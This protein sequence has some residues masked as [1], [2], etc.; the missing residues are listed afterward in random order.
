MQR[1]LLLL[2]AALIAIGCAVLFLDDT[3]R[4]T[5]AALLQ[6]ESGPLVLERDAGELSSPTDRANESAAQLAGASERSQAH[7]ESASDGEWIEGTIALPLGAPAED[8]GLWLIG[9]D[10]VE[11]DEWD[12][13]IMDAPADLVRVPIEN[14]RFRFRQAANGESWVRLDSKW[15]YLEDRLLVGTDEPRLEPKLGAAL[16]VTGIR[17]AGAPADEPLAGIEVE[18]VGVP[19]GRGGMWGGNLGGRKARLDEQGRA[20]F[21]G[22]ATEFT[23]ILR[24]A[25]ERWATFNELGIELRPAQTGKE[26]IEF[27][28]GARLSGFVMDESGKPVAGAEVEWESAN[29]FAAMGASREPARTD[30]QGAYRVYGARFGKG[31]IVA[32][33]DGYLD[34]RIADLELQDGEVRTGLDLTLPRGL[35]I[36]G[37]VFTEGDKPASGAKLTAKR[38]VDDQA[39][40]RMWRGPERVAE[41]EAHADADGHFR[42]SG[43][44]EGEFQLSAEWKAADGLTW[45]DTRLDVAAGTSDL[46]LTVA[47]PQVLIVRVEG[48][49]AAPVQRARIRVAPV[50]DENSFFANFNANLP[51]L[52]L[53]KVAPTS[54]ESGRYRVEGIWKGRWTVEVHADDLIQEVDPLE[55]FADG[56]EILVRMLP[57]ASISGTVIDPDGNP[58]FRATIHL[59]D[60]STA[61]SSPFGMS[62]GGEEVTD[63]TDQSGGFQL[64][65]LAPGSFE[66]IAS[67]D[68][69]APSEVLGLEL[70]PGDRLTGLV[71]RLRRGG[72]I[73]GV[74]FDKQGRP[75]SGRQIMAM[76]QGGATARPASTTSDDV[77]E[78]TITKLQPGTYQVMAQP[79]LAKV[80]REMEGNDNPS[81]ASFMKLMEMTSATVVDGEVTEVVLG[82][83]PETPVRIFGRVTKAGAPVDGGMVTVMREGGS[84][85]DNFAPTDVKKDGTYELEIDGAGRATVMYTRA[86][87]GRSGSE[88]PVNIPER[89]DY[90]LDLALPGGAI[91]GQVVGKDG[92]PLKE[93]MVSLERKTGLPTVTGMGMGNMERTDAAGRFRFDDLEAGVYDL[94]AGGAS[95]FGGGG[96]FAATVIAD[97]EVKVDRETPEL[98]I[99]LG[100]SGEVAGRVLGPDGEPQGGVALFVRDANGALLARVSS[101]NTD[102][103][104]RFVYRGLP[105]GEVFVEA[106]GNSAA[107]DPVRVTVR[108]DERTELDL[109]LSD[110][111]TLIVRAEDAAGNPIRM[112][113]SVKDEAGREVS[114]LRAMSSFQES[115]ARGL[116]T[117]ER[118]VG[119]LPPGKYEVLGTDD[120]G[121]QKQRSVTL[122]GQ[123]ERILRL[124]FDE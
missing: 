118:E 85:L 41:N 6:I 83:P 101:V 99:R 72:T 74:V 67:E 50:S 69:W 122:K 77:G 92:G 124:R 70:R 102:A 35:S 86:G 10:W 93:L 111:T 18:L 113:L 66:L 59:T 78:F 55:F 110:S 17:P 54:D 46:E 61:M 115:M 73:H 100:K 23:W 27:K 71:F 22:L 56:E 80:Q 119:P 117:T 48:P 112:R 95:L 114:G 13:L 120:Q 7:R 4:G 8:L 1:L 105:Q 121:R 91:F 76:T 51:D 65:G 36:A 106:R 103:N 30:H 5:G 32:R 123:K 64:T 89:A 82:A 28:L 14:G 34:A 81:P 38:V 53:P 84:V 75:E 109:R 37:R 31:S 79:D 29:R 104:G 49:N 43:L 90:R 21:H 62:F 57:A 52:E 25:P 58:V 42:I 107:T 26:D 40:A 87:F 39:N 45:H 88:F 63:D 47:P 9:R 20:S 116:N 19:P 94:R 97:I 12:D 3:D 16:D 96:D 98:R 24:S 44:D 108:E 11:P 68:R 60:P 33:A 2:V 15:L